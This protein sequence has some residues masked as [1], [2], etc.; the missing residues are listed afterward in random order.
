MFLRGGKR[1]LRKFMEKLGYIFYRT[2]ALDSIF[3]HPSVPLN[4]QQMKFIGFEGSEETV[5]GKRLEAS[6]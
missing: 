3:I 5:N 6:S 4:V 2:V 1:A